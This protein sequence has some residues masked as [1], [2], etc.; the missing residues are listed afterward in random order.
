MNQRIRVLLLIP[1]LCGGGAEHVTALLARGLSPEKYDVHLGLVTEAGTEGAPLPDWVTVHT[2]GARR[3]RAG[4]FRLLGLVRRLRP[5]VI[6][7]GMVHL[8]FLV[9]SLRPVFPRGTRVLVRQNATV[10]AALA[11]GRR[12]LFTRLLYRLLYPRADGVICQSP[13]MADDLARELGIDAEKLSVLPNPI[14]FEGIR[15]AQDEPYQWSGPGPHLLAVG[16]LAPEKGFDL[17]L[18]ALAEVRSE[19]PRADLVIAGAGPEEAAQRQQCQNLALGEAVV[20]AGRVDR[21]YRFFAGA[22][23]FVLSSRQEGMP[24]A[25][26][27]A[28]AAGLPL[29]ALPASGGVVDLL[30]GCPG[31]WL[32]PA[33]SA[34]E[35]ARALTAALTTLTPGMRFQHSFVAEPNPGVA[36]DLPSSSTGQARALKNS[37]KSLRL[38]QPGAVA[39]RKQAASARARELVFARAIEAYEEL[40]DTTHL[41]AHRAGR[42][43][44]A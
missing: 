17:L 27:E 28:A 34:A 26:L 38:P 36:A 41:A 31:A 12:P 3:V 33:I 11:A 22:S 7:S 24:N 6:L 39:G 16:R 15:A 35:L 1:H 42:V 19:F 18:E 32:A 25:L 37:S 29:V 43:S 23:L 9:L 10:S 20:F 30:A 4:A 40:I 5:Q 44:Q 13:A 8:N 14:D 2:L 21:P